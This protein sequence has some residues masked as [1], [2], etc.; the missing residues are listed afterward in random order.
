MA[1]ITL[2]EIIFFRKVDF[3]KIKKVDFLTSLPKYIL[4]MAYY[5]NA[6]PFWEK[7]THV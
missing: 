2:F 7:F 6:A 5:I 4:L 3:Q 1:Q